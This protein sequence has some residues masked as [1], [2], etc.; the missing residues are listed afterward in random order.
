MEKYAVTV[1]FKTESTGD[2]VFTLTFYN[3]Y[4]PNET[5]AEN[6]AYAKFEDMTSEFTSNVSEVSMYAYLD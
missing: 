3:I 6:E 4:A 2:K 5:E 1:A